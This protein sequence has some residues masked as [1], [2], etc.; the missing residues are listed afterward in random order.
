MKKIYIKKCNVAKRTIFFLK[1]S[2]SIETQ[3]V[4]SE[5]IKFYVGI[6]TYESNAA[7]LEYKVLCKYKVGHF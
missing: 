5:V 1:I 7:L 6:Y 3:H 4:S 2:L